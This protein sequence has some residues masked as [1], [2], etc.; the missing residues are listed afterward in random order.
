MRVS[1]IP[2]T[3]DPQGAILP[4]GRPRLRPARLSPCRTPANPANLIFNF[5]GPSFRTGASFLLARG[6]HLRPPRWVAYTSNESGNSEIYVRPFLAS[7]AGR[8]VDGLAGWRAACR[9]GSFRMCS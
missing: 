9:A 4:P 5:C 7:T 2:I 8:Q 6:A 3:C 1:Y